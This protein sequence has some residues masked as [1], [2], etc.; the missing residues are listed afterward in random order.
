MAGKFIAMCFKVLLLLGSYK[1]FEMEM[2]AH[3]HACSETGINISK[4]K[5]RSLGKVAQTR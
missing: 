1:P 5:V 3:F 4:E 2:Y